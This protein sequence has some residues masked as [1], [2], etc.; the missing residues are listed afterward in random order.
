[1][2][3]QENNVVENEVSDSMQEDSLQYMIHHTKQ[4]AFTS[5]IDKPQHNFMINYQKAAEDYTAVN[6]QEI[7][8]TQVNSE[9]ESTISKT[10][11]KQ[12]DIIMQEPKSIHMHVKVYSS[13]NPSRASMKQSLRSKQSSNTPTNVTSGNGNNRS[14]NS[15]FS[16]SK[17]TAS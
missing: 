5:N 15:S 17:I 14:K 13:H 1:M 12:M 6:M 10:Q 8:V 11:S 9:I 3:I 7:G 2:A 4:D 16:Y